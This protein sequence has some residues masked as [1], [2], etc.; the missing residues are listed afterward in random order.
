MAVLRDQR[1]P[2]VHLERVERPLREPAELT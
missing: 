1:I 2:D